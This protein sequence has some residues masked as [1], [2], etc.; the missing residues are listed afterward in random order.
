MEG[1]EAHWRHT[2]GTEIKQDFI[3]PVGDMD[4]NGFMESNLINDELRKFTSRLTKSEP[5]TWRNYI[6]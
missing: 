4:I 1:I 3:N 5:A 2:T 6:T